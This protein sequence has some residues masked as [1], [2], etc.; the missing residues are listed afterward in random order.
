MN[1]KNNNESK[2]KLKELGFKKGQLDF[3]FSKGRVLVC[4]EEEGYRVYYVTDGWDRGLNGHK[5][6]KDFEI[7]EE[8]SNTCTLFDK[9][10]LKQLEEL[11]FALMDLNIYEK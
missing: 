10:T 11:Y 8:Q 6:K 5:Y 9:T 2:Q 4:L 7:W 3:Q 1:I